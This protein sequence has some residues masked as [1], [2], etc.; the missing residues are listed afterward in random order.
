MV[1]KGDLA[2]QALVGTTGASVLTAAII[3]G[4]EEG[5]RRRCMSFGLQSDRV[6]CIQEDCSK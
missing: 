1:F 5:L 4:H 6:N 2:A 3:S